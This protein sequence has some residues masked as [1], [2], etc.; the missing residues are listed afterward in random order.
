MNIKRSALALAIVALTTSAA[1]ADVPYTQHT[2][3]GAALND[4]VTA[5]SLQGQSVCTVEVA[6]T[7]VETITLEGAVS[8]T[9]V[10]LLASA[11]S[12]TA[13]SSTI[14]APGTFTTS[15]AGLQQFRARV[16]AYT[17]GTATIS[18]NAS[19]GQ[20]GEPSNNTQVTNVVSITA[21]SPIPVTVATPSP[22]SFFQ[23]P[24]TGTSA[25]IVKG[26]AGTFY[27]MT[28]ISTVGMPKPTTCFDNATLATGT[29]LQST[30]LSQDSQLLVTPNGIA[31]T[32][33]LTCSNAGNLSGNGVQ[34][35][36]K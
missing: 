12:G 32:N 30:Q 35:L 29:V 23:T 8:S 34:I 33:G 5:S 21:A 16:S 27:G 24:I 13:V 25:Y 11:V 7:F 6:G 17:S 18:I 28:N 31:F 9:F 2:G 20:S 15:C 1:L 22:Y 26:S 4:A 3:T 14:T 36:Y 19:Q 10:P